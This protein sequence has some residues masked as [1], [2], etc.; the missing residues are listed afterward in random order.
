MNEHE[1]VETILW[2]AMFGLA[3][4]GFGHA[5]GMGDGRPR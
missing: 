5:C 2:I 3:C 4:F 1:L